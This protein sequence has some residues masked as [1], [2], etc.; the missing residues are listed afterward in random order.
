MLDQRRKPD[1]V[2]RR[3]GAPPSWI[4]MGL[5]LL[6]VGV[7]IVHLTRGTTFWFD[8]PNG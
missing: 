5:L 6:L 8:L 1:D 4:P 2:A 3:I 7:F